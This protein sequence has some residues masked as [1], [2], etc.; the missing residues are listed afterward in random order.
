MCNERMPIY[1]TVALEMIGG[2]VQMSAAKSQYKM[3]RVCDAAASD[4]IKM[5][6]NVVGLMLL[7]CH[8]YATC[9]FGCKV[10]P[11]APDGPD[12][13]DSMKIY[14]KVYLVISWLKLGLAT[15]TSLTGDIDSGRRGS[16]FLIFFQTTE[17]LLMDICSTINYFWGLHAHVVGRLWL[18]TYR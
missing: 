16:C 4:G 2:V 10:I 13:P 15:C 6:L 7:I 3:T 1:V 14:A 12:V 8:I 5:R 17:H 9:F 18:M 11:R